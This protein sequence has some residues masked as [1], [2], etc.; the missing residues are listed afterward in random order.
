MTE[1]AWYER[2]EFL[3]LRDKWYKKL[4][5]AGFEDIE[6]NLRTTRQPGPLLK[7]VS[8]GDLARRLYRQDKEDYYRWARH[9]LHEM[10]T[11]TR[12]QRI[13]RRVWELHSEGESQVKI[14]QKLKKTYPEL[15]TK[16]VVAVIQEQM[17][18]MTEK[19]EEEVQVTPEQEALLAVAE[20]IYPPGIA[21]KTRGSQKRG[22]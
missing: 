2:P 11:N 22:E 3:D 17:A 4:E 9:H 12:R 15:R 16:H 8:A 6:T 14:L 19:S 1:K 7:G 13:A 5:R 21:F 20:H 18:L 10:K